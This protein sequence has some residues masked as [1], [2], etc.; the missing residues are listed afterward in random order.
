MI[1]TVNMTVLGSVFTVFPS[2]ISYNSILIEILKDTVALVKQ[3]SPEVPIFI[4]DLY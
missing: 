2:F 3:K 1:S 4:N